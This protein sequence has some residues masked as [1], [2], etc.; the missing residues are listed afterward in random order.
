ME[1]HAFDPMQDS[2]SAQNPY[3]AFEQGEGSELL[4]VESPRQQDQSGEKEWAIH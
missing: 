3:R 4:S 2:G 1:P